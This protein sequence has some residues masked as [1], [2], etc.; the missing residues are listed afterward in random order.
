[1]YKK[2]K[3]Q[4]I[5]YRFSYFF[6][7]SRM[8]IFLSHIEFFLNVDKYAHFEV[9]LKKVYLT[10]NFQNKTFKKKN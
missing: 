5:F 3:I 4:S 7:T 1:M 10:F 8:N 6:P 9:I 2:L